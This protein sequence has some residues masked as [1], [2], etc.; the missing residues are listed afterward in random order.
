MICP[1][2]CGAT[3][4]LGNRVATRACWHRM[5][6]PEQRREWSRHHH[7]AN[8]PMRMCQCGCGRSFIMRGFGDSKRA[9]RRFFSTQCFNEWKKRSPE[10][11]AIDQERLKRCAIGRR[12][13][14]ARRSKE[15][16]ERFA[17]KADAY[18]AGYRAGYNQAY[19]AWQPKRTNWKA[20]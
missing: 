20:S 6:S 4:K 8:R 7:R 11:R 1:C 18:E 13:A 3:L 16:A 2:G 12:R 19:R 15:R 10:Y 5:L 9:R 14:A 17:S